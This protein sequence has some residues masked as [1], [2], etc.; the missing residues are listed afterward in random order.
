[1]NCST[2]GK[3]VGDNMLSCIACT[4]KKNDEAVRRAQYE[5]LLMVEAGRGELKGCRCGDMI[6]V[7]M[8]QSDICFCGR[9]AAESS[10]Q[11]FDIEWHSDAL[12]RVCRLCRNA[13]GEILA[14]AKAAILA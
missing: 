12:N 11:R 6:H 4:L 9:P 7:R 1:M 14:E 5:P 3:D 13:I 8:F 2:C 10:R